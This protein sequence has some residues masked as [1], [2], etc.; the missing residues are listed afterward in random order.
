M[1]FTTITQFIS[2]VGFPICCTVYLIYYMNSEQKQ[3][4]DTIEALKDSI[5][6]LIDKLD[7]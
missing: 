3:M 7:K 6:K 2:S 5:N 1:D 4:R